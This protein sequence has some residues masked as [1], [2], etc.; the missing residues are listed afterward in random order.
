MANKTELEQKVEEFRSKIT[1][2]QKSVQQI[3]KTGMN[4]NILYLIIQRS[5][6]RF[7]SN[8]YSKPLSINDIKAIIAGIEDLPNYM[9]PPEDNQ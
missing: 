4:E 8:R 6:Q 5:S 7:C 1:A 2:I 9:F 3:K